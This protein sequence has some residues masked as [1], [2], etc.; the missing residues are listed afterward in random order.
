[1]LL[2]V[3]A[4]CKY[5]DKSCPSHFSSSSIMHTVTSVL[6]D[7]KE[8][9][10]KKNERYTYGHACWIVKH[11]TLRGY[12][13]NKATVN[14]EGIYTESSKYVCVCVN[15][16]LK[17]TAMTTNSERKKNRWCQKCEGKKRIETRKTKEQNHVS[18]SL[19]LLLQYCHSTFH[20]T[21]ACERWTMMYVYLCECT[22]PN[23]AH[24]CYREI[25]NIQF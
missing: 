2:A 10:R 18:R 5:R 15:V 11:N 4:D 19:S 22:C 17:T 14:P 23:R 8:S 1:L 12:Y 3:F 24:I 9:Y 16:Y 7:Q 20:C 21:H 6:E 13:R 25:N